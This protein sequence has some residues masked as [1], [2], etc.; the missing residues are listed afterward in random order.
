M[1]TTPVS[2]ATHQ[3]AELD[4]RAR[5]AF[6]RIEIR[7]APGITPGF[8]IEGLSPDIN[9]IYGPNA[10]GKST[11]ARAIQALIWPHPTSLRGH[12]LAA[13]FTLGGDQ[14]AI[15]A[16]YG[17]VARFRDSQPADPPLLAPI[18]DR[19]R[20]TLGLHDLLASENQPLAQAIL[21]ES[22]GG[23]DLDA[24]ATELGYR[25]DVPARLEATRDV[26]AALVRV[27]DAERAQGEVAAQARQL[28]IL[29][30]RE[31]L[32]R[33]AHSDAEVIRR[34]LRLA[35]ARYAL[36][37]ARQALDAFPPALAQATG[38]EPQ[39]IAE[40][41]ERLAALHARRAELERARDRAVAERD[42]T[43]LAGQPINDGVLRSLRAARDELARIDT[44]LAGLQRDLKTAIAERQ[45]HQRRLAADL[46]EAQ[47]TSL[48]TEG[49]RE[50][51]ELSHAYDDIR[52]RRRARD[53]VEHWIGNVAPPANIGTL[54]EGLDCL[55]KRLQTPNAAEAGAL[56]GRA[57]MAAYV[58]GILV[59]AGAIW[60]A[61][62]VN[63][64][65]ILF[66]VLGLLLIF[67]AWRYALPAST[68]EAVLWEQRYAALDLPQPAS[69]T[70]PA[71]RERMNDLQEQLRVALVEQE[72]AER[73]SALERE[74]AELERAYAEAEA[75]RA[76]VIA[77][78]GVA[79]DL[80][81]ASLRLLAENL[82]RW[83]A[84][85]TNVR[86]IE[87]RLNAVGAE[88]L[89]REQALRQGLGA[90]GYQTQEWDE[91][92]ADLDQRYQALQ[93]ASARAAAR[94]QELETTIAPEIERF[95][96]ARAAIYER[97]GLRDGDAHGLDERIGQLDGFRAAQRA[98][99]D[100]EVAVREADAALALAPQLRDVDPDELQRR[101]E[102]AEAA[103]AELDAVLREIGEI[104]TRIGDAKRRRDVEDALARRDEALHAL[105]ETRTD[106]E[107]RIAGSTLVA[108]V[109]QET[110]DAAMPIVF[111]RARELFAIIT[112]GRY[113]LEFNE[114]PPPA[115]TARDTATGMTL[116]LD[117]LSSGTRVQLL[118][119]IRLAFVENVESGPKLPVLLDE[120]LGNSDEL[121]AGA[122][123]DAA[124]EISRNGRQ[125]FYFTA[126]GDEVARWQARLAQIPAGTRPAVT[127]ID[128][129]EIRR[130]A[131]FDRLPMAVPQQVVDRMPV[132]APDG[133][134]RGAYGQALKV[135]GID[136]W[137]DGLGGVHLWHLVD[138]LDA[139][140]ALLVQDVRTWGQLSGLVA[141]G[142][143]ESL[144]ALGV[145]ERIWRGAEA[146]ARLLETALATWRSGHARP[147]TEADLAESGL[148]P[149][150]A[151]ARAGAL[152]NASG[153]DGAALIDRLRAENDA[154]LDA[155]AIDALEAWLAGN[156]HIARGEA[157]G[158][159]E[160][161]GR[162]LR[163]A[164]ADLQ[165]GTV[166]PADI[167]ALLAQLPG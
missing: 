49:L 73:W 7:K 155:L 18:D 21:K 125:V 97:L 118:M 43:H 34:A 154:P 117:Q 37:Q 141:S 61:T 158:R 54:R 30:E 38:D 65:W 58:G 74:R 128:L 69:W 59:I 142:G 162:L 76:N 93:D 16:D 46:S 107:S 1:S 111:H 164:R 75:R 26:D 109:Q 79:P 4:Q 166:A 80:S 56:I 47:I 87:A 116:H 60:L 98:V 139:L 78:Y 160:L 157:L 151:M 144:T 94:A 167:D 110:R 8:T 6:T 132:P 52:V 11:T 165:R 148:V 138:D 45:S 23:F 147:V 114:G 156:G 124:I 83:Q 149:A 44:D 104:Q 63:P 84:A 85:D 153:Q 129:A 71:V 122:I 66:A 53:E 64:L 136:P 119:A 143:I 15:E 17:R 82:S 103:G 35:Q 19:L 161:R 22:S 3:A 133:L 106:L 150:S 70:I 86:A 51:A 36:A 41:D 67:F 55:Q 112:R 108:Y 99:R 146:R 68:R 57:R 140:H 40:L 12:A 90:F 145:D 152:L 96:R 48:D 113:G 137:S 159:E 163:A 115:F 81:E 88:R 131:S 28:T 72:K 33:Q 14:W 32:A 101:L 2:P 27:R 24:V 91:H 127:V 102:A 20:Y 42:A 130:D 25:S 10:S 134:D 126:Q 121:R 92:I 50:L 135:P 120:T 62:F 13:G 9:I 95:S 100:R 105:R 29:R 77:R 5:L 39:R 31:R 123:I 89:K